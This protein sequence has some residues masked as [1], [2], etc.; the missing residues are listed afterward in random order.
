MPERGVT[1]L[2]NCREVSVPTARPRLRTP[3]A[4]E[5]VEVAVPGRAGT[6]EVTLN[7]VC[8]EEAGTRQVALE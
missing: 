7:S 5:P 3:Q 8:R 1:R 2:V 6:I 4:Q